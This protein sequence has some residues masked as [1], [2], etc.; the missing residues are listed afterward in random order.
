[1]KARSFLISFVC[2]GVLTAQSRPPRLLLTPDDFQRIETGAAAQKWMAVVRDGIIQAAQAFPADQMQKYGLKEWAIPPEGGQWT[3]WYVCP[4][5]GVSLRF[6][7]PSTHLCPVDNQTFT[8]KKL[9]LV[10]YTRRHND[11]AAAARDNGLAYRFTGNLAYAQTAAR[12]LLAY[13]DAYNS[14]PIHDTNG[15]IN[16][17]SGGRVLSQTLDESVWLIPMAWAYDLIAGS[18]VLNESQQRHIEQDLLRS[19]VTVIARNDAKTSNW[20]S[21]HNAAIGAVGFTLNDAVLISKAI[22]GPSGFR[23]QMRESV[24]DDGF[25]YEGAWG[26]HFYA[27]DALMQLAEMA[28]RGGIDLYA[29][30]NLRKM[31]EGPLLF[32][33]P[34]WTLPNF[35]DSGTINLLNQDR[36]Y[37]VAYRRYRD[38]RFAALLGKR[39]RGREAL[40]WGAETIDPAPPP[41]LGSVYL[42]ASGNVVFRAPGSDHTVVLKFG[43]HGGWHGHYDKLHFVSYARGGIMAVDPGTQSYAAPTHD[44]WDKVTLA[45]NT[46]VVDQKSQQEATGALEFFFRWPHFTAAVANAGP[47]YRQATLRRMMLH[48]ADYLLDVFHVTS[49]DGA[50]HQFDWIY[51]NYGILETDLPLQPYSGFPHTDGY[52]HLTENRAATTSSTWRVHFD[53]N[54]DLEG[55]FGSVYQSAASVQSTYTYSREQAASGRFSGKAAY[56]FTTGS[57]YALFQAPV[58][59]SAPSE[60][61]RGVS[62]M[63]YGDGSKNK[64]A[65]R[66]YDSTDERFVYTV[67]PIDWTGW[68]LIRATN[69]ESWQHYLGNND[70]VF[71][72]PA[73]TVAV[74]LSAAP[75][76][77]TKG[78]LYVDDVKLDFAPGVEMTVADFERT[79]RGLRL[80]MAGAPNTTVITGKGLG[81]NLL[82]PVPY[83]M[84]RR[85]ARET[86]FVSLLEITDGGSSARTVTALAPGLFRVQNNRVTDEIHFQDGY[87]PV[88][89]TRYFNRS[90]L[91]GESWK[92]CLPGKFTPR[93]P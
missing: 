28:A 44:T 53:M 66:I 38:P 80:T 50:E 54:S 79:L 37:E 84:A 92:G 27:L 85:R 46:V 26:Y 72:P 47:A 73:R 10:I 62:L 17:T 5:H 68:K 25:W 56:E 81:P 9:D 21:W 59:A 3:L 20:Q 33:F 87:C 49:N 75:G 51:H 45:H 6:I 89:V 83:V 58:P 39:A 61:P 7:P 63:I 65:I 74:E 12:I 55:A 86:Y 57:G 23:F 19:A 30:P 34:D 16:A 93:N 11:N 2:A 64:L 24:L 40:F 67:G 70:G 78:A 41:E 4:V 18:G 35:N 32:A 77:Q 43:P 15:R 90:G 1:M 29:E 76:A 13:A 8:D 22:D 69:P 82:Q 48:T 31:F 71:D 52:Q 42:P 60:V 36:F 91:P 14:Y 88:S